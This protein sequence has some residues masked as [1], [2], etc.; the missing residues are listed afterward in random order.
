MNLSRPLTSLIPSLEGAVLT[1]LADAEADF[2]GIQVWEVIGKHSKDGVNKALQKLA[3]QGIVNM[4]A[5]GNSNLYELNREHL[6]AK[7]IIGTANVRAE[8]FR[9][10]TQ[11]VASWVLLPECVA[12]FGS[13]AR[14]NMTPESDIDV[15]V[16][17]SA[18]IDFGDMAW[19]EQITNFALKVER[20]TGNSVQ[21]FEVGYEDI[22]KELAIEDD[23]I[24]S[25]I[26]EGVVV[27]GPTDYLRTLHNK[28]GVM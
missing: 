16:S 2:T 3:A 26:D 23:V 12:I 5:S 24:Y 27:Y 18:E 25:I 28:V 7:Y 20:W 13:T 22:K 21:I 1:V 10:L 11:E 4:R 9:L 19:R 6:L 14:S 8:F 17:R 15:F